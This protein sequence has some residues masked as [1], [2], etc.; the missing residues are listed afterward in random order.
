MAMAMSVFGDKLQKLADRAKEFQ[1]QS[2]TTAP[3]L[4]HLH[5]SRKTVRKTISLV[6]THGRKELS[7][8]FHK[9]A[10]PKKKPDDAT[11]YRA[12]V[13]GGGI[14]SEEE[15]RLE[16]MSKTDLLFVD[17]DLLEKDRYPADAWY[18]LQ[19]KNMLYTGAMAQMAFDTGP[20]MLQGYIR[21]ELSK[22]LHMEAG[23]AASLIGEPALMQ[24]DPVV[25]PVLNRRLGGYTERIAEKYSMTVNERKE[26]EGIG[27]EV[28]EHFAV[29]PLL[30][31]PYEFAEKSE[32]NA[33]VW[34]ADDLIAIAE[35]DTA[36][37]DAWKK[38]LE[39]QGSDVNLPIRNHSLLVGATA[40][41]RHIEEQ[42]KWGNKIRNIWARFRDRNK[43]LV[44]A[45]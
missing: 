45:S 4:D 25:T 5:P 26:L 20:A 11:V 38:R 27:I 10:M 7:F 8:V 18:R 33:L 13:F 35:R 32:G 6:L 14:Q 17:P 37:I 2:G 3:S 41:V 31:D 43:H 44:F 1:L 30:A 42:G 39:H 16:R 34:S 29:A 28:H 9:E 12:A 22:R 36:D 23:E 19:G 21:D 24:A 15:K 40:A